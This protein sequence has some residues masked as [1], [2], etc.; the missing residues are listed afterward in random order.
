MPDEEY[1]GKEARKKLNVLDELI[2]IFFILSLTL[3]I[4]FFNILLFVILSFC[5]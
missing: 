4:N 2:P 5:F 3:S 1:F